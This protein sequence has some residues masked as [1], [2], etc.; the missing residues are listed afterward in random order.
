MRAQSLIALSVLAALAACKPA[1]EEVKTD[2]GAAP[3]VV[4]TLASYP[5]GAF[6]ENLAVA[7]DGAVYF[8]SYFAKALML[9]RPGSQATEFAA[10]PAHPVGVLQTADGFVVTAHGTPFT[11]APAF[12]SSNEVL[13]L[14]A[15]GKVTKTVRVPDAKFLNG[16]V[17]LKPDLVLIADSV[18]GVIWALTPSTGTLRTWL[19]DTAL[20]ADPAST[21]Q[22]PA[23]NGLKLHDGILYISNSSRGAV[24]RQALTADGEPQGTPTPFVQPGPVDDFAFA[25]DGAIYAATHGAALLKI[26]P[27]GTVSKV[28]ETGCDGCTSVGVTGP[29]DAPEL[30]VLTTGNLVEGG[31]A[32]AR[33]LQIRPGA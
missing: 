10:L 6:L 21:E 11:E 29:A 20:T 23:A 12:L 27:D 19:R 28:I 1:T 3:A 22:R 25:P 7:P 2:T 33:V 32:P 8:T 24:Y 14:D 13:F 5:H 18:A 16:L 30:V 4:Q 26:L 31:D 17:Q 15:A 9:L